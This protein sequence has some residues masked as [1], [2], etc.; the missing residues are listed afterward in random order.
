M[1]EFYSWKK[2]DLPTELR[3][4]LACLRIT[5]DTKEVRQIEELSRAKIG[6]P[7]FL[8]WVDRHR[9]AP[10]VYQNLRRYGGNGVPAAA[11]SALRSRFESNARRSLANAREL[12]RLYELFQE[13]GV[14]CIPLKGSILALQVYGNL[15]GRH[16]GDIDLLVNLRHV[17]LADRLLRERYR[18]IRPGLHLTHYQQKQYYRL[19]EQLVYINDRHNIKLE[20]HTRLFYNRPYFALDLTQLQDRARHIN[21]ADSLV[22]VM[23]P[24]D[25]YLYLCDHGAQHYWSRL[26]WLSDLAEIIRQDRVTDW[27]QLLKISTTLGVS[28]PLTQGMF[29]AHLLFE[30]PLPDQIRAYADR[31]QAMPYLTEVALRRILTPKQDDIIETLYNHI[32]YFPKLYTDFNC[33]IECLKRLFFYSGDWGTIPLPD[34]LFPYFFILRPFM[35]LYRRLRFN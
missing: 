24:E 5:P 17:D 30:T 4:I 13:N 25:N 27:E 18:R 12:V 14:V 20:L 7:D 19:R 15:A 29:L 16:A 8:R 2:F 3:L 33:K 35:W 23:S 28:R 31:D 10:L 22:P 11:M 21:V 6:W 9:V 26:F 34:V 1:G 32:I